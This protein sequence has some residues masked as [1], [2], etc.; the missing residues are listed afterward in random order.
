MIVTEY[1]IAV[2]LCVS[3]GLEKKSMGRKNLKDSSGASNPSNLLPPVHTTRK[4]RE[5]E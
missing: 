3:S 1:R 4:H 2:K 5:R